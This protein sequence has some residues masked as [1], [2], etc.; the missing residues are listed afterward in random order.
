MKKKIKTEQ[1]IVIIMDAIKKIMTIFLGPFLT[2]YFISTSTN[3]ILNIAI[4]YIFTYATMALSTLV[5]A[6]LAEKRNRIK[7]FRIGI[8]LNFIYILIIILLKEKII[9]Y[10]PI[11]SILYGISAS[12]YYFPYN[13]FIIN[14]VK[15]TERTNYM[16]KL[17]I[18]ISVV[19][20][21]FPIIF[22]SIITITNYILTAVIVL[23]ISLIQIIL[24]FFITDNH[25]GDLEEYNLKKAWLELKKNKQVINCLAGEFFIGMN[26]CNGTLETVMVILILNSFKTNI[27]LGIIT[28]IATLLS[29]LVV[30]IY[31][32]IYNKRDDKKVIIISSI[33]PVI[34]LIIFLI[35]K[36]NTTVIIYKFSYV[37]FAEILS[38]VRK[39]KIFNLS[40]SK[41]VNK[42][43]QCEFN[44]IREVTLN[45]GRVTGYT[46]LLLAGLTQSAVV[47]NIVTIILTLSLLVM[48]I[49]LTKV[50]KNNH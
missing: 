46:L 47:L 32:L 21:L 48:S 4:Y 7:I 43:N 22:G 35:L 45:V 12:C 37:I 2:A 20:I 44:A 3:S 50:K 36:T 16:V 26:I 5:V 42:S 9:N 27:N 6:V 18:T 24:S 49:N 38:L 13:L 34:S 28:S 11:I 31:G 19:G 10:L 15:N 14:K 40:N 23:F 29:I 39:I 30:K 33:I 17:F 1:N 25:N 41:I 8:I